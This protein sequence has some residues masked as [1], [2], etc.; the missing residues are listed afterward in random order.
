MLVETLT[1]VKVSI[2]CKN[3]GHEF[4]HITEAGDTPEPCSE[5]LTKIIND[6]QKGNEPLSCPYCHSSLSPQQMEVL[7]ASSDRCKCWVL[8][9]FP[10]GD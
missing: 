7:K 8:R 6:L 10:E 5:E 1:E 4:I 9:M 2:K 3:C